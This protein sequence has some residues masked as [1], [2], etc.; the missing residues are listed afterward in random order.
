M[1]TSVLLGRPSSQEGE[2]ELHH[3]PNP[4]AVSCESRSSRN[5]KLNHKSNP[6]A[7]GWPTLCLVR[8]PRGRRACPCLPAWRGE[9]TDSWTRSRAPAGCW[10]SHKCEACLPSRLLRVLNAWHVTL[11]GFLWVGCGPGSGCQGRGSRSRALGS[12]AFRWGPLWLV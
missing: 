5:H 4:D 8:V 3:K 7:V 12:R 9:S 6:D 10:T 11:A 2:S 1:L